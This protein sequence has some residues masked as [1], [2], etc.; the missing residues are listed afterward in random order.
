MDDKEIN[1][2]IRRNYLKIPIKRL[3]EIIGRS[4]T[5]VVGRMRKMEL[6]VPKEIIEKRKL[7]SRRKK[8]DI[9][10]NKGLKQSSYMSAEQIEKTAATRFKKGSTPHNT[11]ANDGEISIRKD[12][13]G[14]LYKYIRLGLGKWE[15]LHRIIWIKKNGDIPK[16]SCIIF[17]NGNTMDFSIG[18]L[19][20]VT[21]SEHMKNNSY[22][23]YG[24]EI[25]GLIQLRGALTR[26]INK[27]TKKISNE[28]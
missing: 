1:D 25:A 17:K 14:R 9:P 7:D 13:D 28:K 26:Q 12:K 21:R 24:K 23:R 19:E 11:K 20:C 22:H 8:G 4:Y 6:V 3:A 16:N 5:L 18:N 10:F 2:F 27:H 15:L